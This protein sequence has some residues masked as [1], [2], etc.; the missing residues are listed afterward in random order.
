[1]K[2]RPLVIVEPAPALNQNRWRRCNFPGCTD[3][4]WKANMR[5]CQTHYGQR[6]TAYDRGE[7]PPKPSRTALWCEPC[8]VYVESPLHFPEE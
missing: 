8:Q 4:R 7:R 6:V 2:L 1:V 3:W 5:R